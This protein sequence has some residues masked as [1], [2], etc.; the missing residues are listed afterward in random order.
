MSPGSDQSRVFGTI[1]L[2]SGTMNAKMK[3]SGTPDSAIAI[4]MSWGAD[5]DEGSGRT[6]LFSSKTCFTNRSG[7]SLTRHTCW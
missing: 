4:G 3:A 7:Y 1:R 5:D 2:T 6:P